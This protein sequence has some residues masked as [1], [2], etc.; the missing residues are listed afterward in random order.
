M[1]PAID[2]AHRFA[3]AVTTLRA[4]HDF[5]AWIGQFWIEGCSA[6]QSAASSGLSSGVDDAIIWYETADTVFGFLPGRDGCFSLPRD[7]PLPEFA[8]AAGIS[9]VPYEEDIVISAA[10]SDEL[11][12]PR[13]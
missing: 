9:S 11:Q 2:V 6:A 7:L 10:M 4:L 5:D 3:E 12:S 1:P 13:S 8:F